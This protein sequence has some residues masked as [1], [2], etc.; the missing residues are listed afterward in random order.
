MDGRP[1]LA[2]IDLLKG[3]AM[4]GVIA[5]HAL[6]SDE[7]HDAWGP[8]HFGQA[9]PIFL[10]LMALNAAGSLRRRGPGA[11]LGGLLTR[12]YLAGRARRLL[13]P[14]AVVWV[15]ALVLGAIEDDLDFGPTTFV[16]VLPL[17][18]PGNYF[19][20]IAFEFVLVFPLVYWAFRRAPVATIAACFALDAAFEL[21]APHVFEGAYPFAYDA[22]ILRYL[23]QIALGLWIAE[24]TGLTDRRNR[25]VLVLAAGSL[26]Y[27]VAERESPAA[28]DWLRQDFGTTTNFLAAPYAAALVLL[29]LRLLPE[30]AGSP[31]VRALAAIGRASWHIFLVQIVWFAL[32]DARGADSYALHAAG[33][34]AIGYALYRYIPPMGGSSRVLAASVLVAAL[35]A[36]LAVAAISS[37]GSRAVPVEASLPA[38]GQTDLL[39]R[40][41]LLVELRHR[42]GGRV[43][44]TPALRRPDGSATPLG[45]ARA[46]RLARDRTRTVKLPLSTS[47][48][49]ALAGCSPGRIEV[50]VK[51]KGYSKTRRASRKL[52]LDP[53]DC[54]RFF[55]SGAFWNTPLPAGAVP[56]PTSAEVTAELVRSVQQGRAQGMPATINTDAYTPPVYT[57]GPD[58]PRVRVE[59]DQPPG[60][61]D[62]LRAAFESVPL[63]EHARGATGTDAELIVWQPSTDTLWDFWQLRR[64]GA[65]WQA[66][67]GGRLT[68]VS[69]G[70]AT[71]PSNWGASASGLPLAGGLIT[72]R[73]LRSGRIDHAL[74][75]GVPDVRA[76]EFARPAK[77]TDGVST[78]R[79]AVPEG[80]RFRLDPALDV[81]SL[82][83]P[84]AAATIARAAQR[85][86]IVV[87]EQAG[88]VALYAQNASTFAANPYVEPFGGL[89]PWDVMARFPWDRLQLMPMEL[90][91]TPGA[92]RPLPRAQDVLRGCA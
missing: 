58:Q 52:R 75:L 16:G 19:V 2:Q 4:L 39:T 78:C 46:L 9:V 68:N 24:H 63:P 91:G 38:S 11:S 28:F 87:R 22:A 48:R 70:S 51:G 60:I 31:P 7:L 8:L 85:Y 40:G 88:A 34:C 50:T 37:A 74:A 79:H 36:A 55:S 30:R 5:L 83:L 27:L 29:G 25:W 69:D 49:E 32:V 20:T 35:A 61:A 42:S 17:T 53:P 59:L 10:V 90:V 41:A 54:G 73:E 12:D 66:T 14:F 13:V 23:G 77:R 86:G 80:A 6:T 44:L 62:D 57:V 33:S 43:T 89:A 71:F 18:G 72:A 84:P 47:G 81:D 3:V 76:W 92:E 1:H 64:R 56:D 65:R 21:I 45:T 82:G 26:A 67:W 15:A